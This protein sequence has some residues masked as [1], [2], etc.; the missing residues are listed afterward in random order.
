V[1]DQTSSTPIRLAQQWPWYPFTEEVV[2]LTNDNDSI[3]DG[4]IWSDHVIYQYFNS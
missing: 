3:S 1:D 2:I 4:G